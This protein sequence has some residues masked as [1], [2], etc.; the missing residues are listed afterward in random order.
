MTAT[1]TSN[2]ISAASENASMSRSGGAPVVVNNAPTTNINNSGKSAT[3]IPVSIG[4][5]STLAWNGTNF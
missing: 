5:Q 4:D 1:K 3:Y 2:L